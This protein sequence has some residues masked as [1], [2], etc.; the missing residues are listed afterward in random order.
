VQPLLL[1][2]V[3]AH[4]LAKKTKKPGRLREVYEVWAK[5]K[6]LFIAASGQS[7]AS[8]LSNAMAGAGR[9][10]AKMHNY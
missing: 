5:N 3:L 10:R 9:T 4:G 6:V 8:V 1:A 2:T 7:I